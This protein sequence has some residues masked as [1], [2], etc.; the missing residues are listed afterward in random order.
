MS[1]FKYREPLL[2]PKTVEGKTREQLL[3]MKLQVDEERAKIK[4]QI[5]KAQALAMETG[6]YSDRD[7]YR[8]ANNAMSAFG[9]QSQRIQGAIA[10]RRDEK[11]RQNILDNPRT[12]EREFITATKRFVS[13]ELYERICQAAHAAQ[14]AARLETDAQVTTDV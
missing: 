7:W 11:K 14:E 3:E 5:A 10:Q 6:E 13:P 9:R 2:D 8:R 12:W 4:S 1:D